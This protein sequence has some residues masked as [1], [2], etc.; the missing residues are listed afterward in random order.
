ML[1][2]GWIPIKHAKS[3]SKAKIGPTCILRAHAMESTKTPSLGMLSV[4]KDLKEN[5]GGEHH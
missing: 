5:A 4:T 1:C 3:T 2:F